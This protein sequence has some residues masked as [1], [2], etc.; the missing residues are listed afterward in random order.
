MS[1]TDH[2]LDVAVHVLTDVGCSREINEDSVRSVQPH[3]LAIKA[4]RGVLVVVA[5]GMGGHSAGE[6]ASQLAVNTIHHAYYRHAGEAGPALRESFEEAN[7]VIYEAAGRDSRLSGMG[8]TCTAL[9]VCEGRAF[10]AHVGDTRL[11]LVRGKEIYLM[12]EDD[13]AVRAM[14]ANG[15][16]TAAEARH[17]ADRN[18]ILRALGTHPAVTVSSWTQG[19][20]CRAGDAF[21]LCSD[22]LHELVSDDE[23][24]G[25]VVGR[26]D[27]AACE[28]LVQLARSRGGPD[29]ITVALVT[30]GA[31]GTPRA[32]AETRSLT[33]LQ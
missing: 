4:A 11:Y 9:A 14:V 30:L 5:D 25:I 6:V 23:I 10:C 28:A 31:G 12:T 8:T 3:D 32:V 15:A 1:A 18:V 26:S 21:L 17:H 7:R 24:R 33:V 16:L 29:N 22:G 2:D 13:S 19:F 20:P 27:L